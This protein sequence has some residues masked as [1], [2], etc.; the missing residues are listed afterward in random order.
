MGSACRCGCDDP[1]GADVHRMVAAL[2]TDDV[3]GAMDAGLL[4]TDGCN[5]CSSECAMSLAAAREGR[6]AAL[7]ARDRFRAREARLLRRQRERLAKR[8]PAS[9]AS[10]AAASS[11]P[12]AA[13]AALQRALG[14]AAGRGR[15]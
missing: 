14:R 1:R 3:D 11:L 10:S 12:P 15:T 13:A 9:T 2:A 5:G 4:A 6:R 8:A 7:A